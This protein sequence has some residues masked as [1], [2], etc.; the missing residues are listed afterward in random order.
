MYFDGDFLTGGGA[1]PTGKMFE[2][3]AKRAY[4]AYCIQMEFK[5]D[6]GVML[7]PWDHLCEETQDAW[8]NVVVAIRRHDILRKVA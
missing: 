3:I 8:I 2:E 5:D 6:H 1:P 4:E 7:K